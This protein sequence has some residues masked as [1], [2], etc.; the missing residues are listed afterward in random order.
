MDEPQGKPSSAGRSPSQDRPFAWTRILSKQSGDRKYQYLNEEEGQ[1]P[2]ASPIEVKPGGIGWDGSSIILAGAITLFAAGQLITSCANNSSTSKQSERLLDSA[3]RIN[4]AA[5]SFSHSSADMS[6]SFNDAIIQLGNQ[7]TNTQAIVSN[8]RSEFQGTQRAF[9]FVKSVN[10]YFGSASNGEGAFSWDMTIENSGGTNPR[11]L[12][13]RIN[14]GTGKKFNAGYTQLLDFSKD[15][16]VGQQLMIGPHS[17][18]TVATCAAL[19]SLF[20]KGEEGYWYIF[21]RLTYKDVFRKSHITEF[22]YRNDSHMP[23]NGNFYQ[24]LFMT[25]CEGINARHNCA[26]EDC[27]DY[28]KKH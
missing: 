17:E 1:N 28:F 13:M 16:L 4:D 27:K 5:D 3:Y 2:T 24:T 26:D 7:A 20:M 21:G 10:T 23:P 22:C 19:A 14:C 18:Q 12:V 6:R 8:A 15:L 25:P 9:I 11:D